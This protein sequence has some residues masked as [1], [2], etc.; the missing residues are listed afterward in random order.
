MATAAT[1]HVIHQKIEKTG[2]K[3]SEGQQQSAKVFRCLLETYARKV[4]IRR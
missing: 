3:K 4:A 2:Q 1:E